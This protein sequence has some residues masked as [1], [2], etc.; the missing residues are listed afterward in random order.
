M[1]RLNPLYLVLLSVSI[2]LLSLFLL[3]QEKELVNKQQKEYELLSLKSKEYMN[4]KSTWDNEEYVLKTL[5]FILSNK[6][7]KNKR[8]LRVRVN[9][10]IKIKLESKDPMALN[11]FLNM[12]LNKKLN[13]KKLSLNKTYISLEV[14]VK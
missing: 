6:S 9:N 10:T 2:F 11:K 13:I 14:G 12:V 8:V 1:K 3:R 5:D 4:L 7:F